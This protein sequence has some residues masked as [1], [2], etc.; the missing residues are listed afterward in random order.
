[1]T[2][3]SQTWKLMDRNGRREGDRAGCMLTIDHV[4]KVLRVEA[5]ESR[6]HACIHK[7]LQ[8]RRPRIVPELREGCDP[9]EERFPSTKQGHYDQD[10]ACSPLITFASA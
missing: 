4:R 8:K 3:L 6:R 9:T 2:G 5:P 1:M 10:P 7:H